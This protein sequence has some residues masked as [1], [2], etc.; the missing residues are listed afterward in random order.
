MTEQPSSQAILTFR[1]RL[2]DFVLSTSFTWKRVNNTTI[3]TVV[4]I[5]AGTV[6]YFWYQDGRL[7]GQTQKP[8]KTIVLTPGD[9][10]RLEVL[11]TNDPAFDPIANAPVGYPPRRTLEFVR[12]LDPSIERYRI[13]QKVGSG[14]WTILGYVRDNPTQWSY[15]YQTGRLLDLTSY[16]WRVVPMNAAGNDGTPVSLGPGGGG[17]E[18]IVRTPDAPT[19]NVA[20]Q[21]YADAVEFYTTTL[22]LMVSSITDNGDNSLT[23]LFGGAVTAGDFVPNNFHEVTQGHGGTAIVQAGANGI[24]LTGAFTSPMHGDSWVWVGQPPYVA[25]GQFG[26]VP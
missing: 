21:S 22:L 4:P 5:L 8:T 13:E 10:A 12:S 1:P 9:S 23:M 7:V 3:V 18:F 14:A 20:F 6:Y 24:K 2:V 26:V 19:F 17:A 11:Q 25:P 15:R 16:S